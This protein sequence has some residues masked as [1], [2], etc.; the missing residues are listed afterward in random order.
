MYLRRTAREIFD[1]GYTHR[2]NQKYR[3]RIGPFL[4][5][6]ALVFEFDDLVGIDPVVSRDAESNLTWR[7][8][9]QQRTSLDRTNYRIDT[10]KLNEGE[11]AVQAELKDACR[12]VVARW[13][14]P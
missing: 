5:E 2:F 1:E 10:S 7:T 8:N 12:C 11:C 4:N 3:I 13:L 9:D 14:D 6:Q